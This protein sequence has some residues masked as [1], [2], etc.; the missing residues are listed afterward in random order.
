MKLFNGLLCLLFCLCGVSSA[1]NPEGDLELDRLMLVSSSLSINVESYPT[2]EAMR[3]DTEKLMWL[4]S[5]AL[6]ILVQENPDEKDFLE[7]F[8]EFLSAEFCETALSRESVAL[9]LIQNLKQVFELT[10]SDFIAQSQDFK[11]FNQLFEKL[12]RFI[13]QKAEGE[14]VS[15]QSQL[16][17]FL[18]RTLNFLK[19]AKPLY[20]TSKLDEA[21][22]AL[23]KAIEFFG[24][25]SYQPFQY[26][27]ITNAAKIV[28]GFADLRENVFGWLSNQRAL[29][30]YK[31]N[32]FDTEERSVL[33][34]IGRSSIRINY[35]K[36]FNKEYVRL[37][38]IGE[39]NFLTNGLTTGLPVVQK[40]SLM[41]DGG[42]KI[43]VKHD[44]YGRSVLL[45]VPSSLK[46]S[47]IG[48]ASYYGYCDAKTVVIYT[49]GVDKIEN[50]FN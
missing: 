43:L 25:Y 14:I 16:R 29:D 19:M 10:A 11:A 24:Y 27:Y 4:L 8:L 38:G 7:S 18:D 46:I 22:K 48:D 37:G 31:I 2:L 32:L 44:E 50:K 42:F 30:L 23:Q 39:Y 15:F 45:E 12:I 33:G 5:T 21:F 47:Q 49:N 13:S 26:D 17:R 28:V 6:N 9:F 34:E 40:D 20:D 35:F 1:G 36:N 3:E 41:F